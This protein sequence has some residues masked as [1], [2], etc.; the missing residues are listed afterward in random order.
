MDACGGYW[1]YMTPSG[2]SE[3]NS[4]KLSQD[5]CTILNWVHHGAPDW[6]NPL[7]F[8]AVGTFAFWLLK[9]FRAMRDSADIWLWRS[10]T[11]KKVCVKNVPETQGRARLRALNDL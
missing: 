9:G 8:F 7:M 6:S 3:E 2:L 10:D 1:D 11:V 5:C 4:V